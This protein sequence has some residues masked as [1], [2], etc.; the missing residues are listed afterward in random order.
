MPEDGECEDCHPSCE[1]CS[2]EEE[3]QCTKCAKGLWVTYV[4]LVLVYFQTQQFHA[5]LGQFSCFLSSSPL[6]QFLTMQ[7]TCVSKCPGGFF[8]SRLSSVCEA[9]PPGC[10]Q[11]VDA[12]RCT[13]CQNT[14]KAPLFLQNGQCVKQ[15]VRSGVSCRLYVLLHLMSIRLYVWESSA[16]ELKI[17]CQKMH[18]L[19]LILTFPTQ[20]L[21]AIKLWHPWDWK[22]TSSLMERS[23]KLHQHWDHRINLW[24]WEILVF[25]LFFLTTNYQAAF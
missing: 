14:R 16:E 9:C 1:S 22:N 2:G 8:A 18:L 7:Q 12:Q 3:N 25:I 17:K 11:C 21:C 5:A 6:G 15:C 23:L 4:D 10:L 20:C 24:P 19:A 13:R